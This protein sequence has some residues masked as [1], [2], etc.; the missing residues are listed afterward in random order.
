[1]QLAYDLY[2]SHGFTVIG[3]HDNSVL[4]EAVR[5]FVRKE[6]MRVPIAIDQA[7]GRTLAAYAKCGIDGYPGFILLGPDG[8]ILCSDRVLPG[9]SLRKFRLELIR[10]YVMGRRP[11]ESK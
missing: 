11:A 5:E 10:E 3:V 1:M 4:P 9:P 6:K 2:A 8:R 7:D